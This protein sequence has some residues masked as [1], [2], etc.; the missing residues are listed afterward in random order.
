VIVSA[1]AATLVAGLV[2]VPAG[3]ATRPGGPLALA[4][5]AYFGSYTNPNPS[6]GV[7]GGQAE[8][9]AREADLGRT[10]NIDNRFYTWGQTIPTSMETWDIQ[11]GRIPMITWGKHDSIDIN[12]GSQD[13]WIRAQ[14]RGLAALGAP[15]FFRFFAEPDGD[16]MRSIVHSPADYIA[17]WRRVYG[18]FQ[19]EGATNAVWVWCPT[20]WKFVQKSPW[21]PDYYPGDAYVDWV[22]ADGYNWAPVKPGSVW[23]TFAQTFQA[24]YDWAVTANKPIMIAETGVLERN[25]GEKASW[26]T[27]AR[28]AIETTF[29]MIQAFVYFDTRV[30]EKDGLTYDWR[31]STSTS[32]YDAYKA[33][34]ADP[35][36]N[37]GSAPPPPPPPPP[38]GE[39]FR[40]GF[41]AGL[42]AWT[43]VT[44]LTLD[45]ANAPPTGTTPSVR[46]SVVS[47]RAYAYRDLDTGYPKVC[48][49]TAVWLSSIGTDA[50]ALLKLRTSGNVSIGRVFVNP[51]R[52][53]LVRA[54]V[55]GTTVSSGR[56]LPTG[57]NTVKAC[58]EVGT[59]GNWTLFLNGTQIGSWTLNNGTTPIG[60]VQLG[61]DAVR[62]FTVNFD[63]VVAT[64][65]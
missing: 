15:F 52:V 35:Y 3:A 12:S 28:N 39:I 63:D 38:S 37:P 46:A 32:A 59:S 47:Q 64:D 5:G 41:D 65:A 24:F 61:D 60:R 22:A 33:M 44:N 48:V 4:S 40:D 17:A 45:T 19:Q 7:Q 14:A 27:A 6:D 31:A 23:R 54:D 29:P 10:L 30:V 13:A 9:L 51:S 57:W 62:T 11:N 34:A 21:P 42:G 36:F 43:S 8:I 1:I 55:P 49:S 16:Y 18:I 53:L 2:T 26:I 58:A 50:V 20:A 56:T 25:A